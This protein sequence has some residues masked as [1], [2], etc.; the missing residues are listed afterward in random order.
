MKQEQKEPQEKRPRW[1]RRDWFEGDP[2]SRRP[3]TTPAFR[4]M[5]CLTAVA[6]SLTL[7][8]FL[9]GRL[10]THP[11]QIAP[12]R[13][14]GVPSG[15]VVALSRDPFSFTVGF[16]ILAGVFLLVWIVVAWRKL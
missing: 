7:A 8:S 3:R 11:E 13:D 12:F 4:A 9:M 6:L 10:L 5:G 14:T 15:A 2:K 16:G 1:K